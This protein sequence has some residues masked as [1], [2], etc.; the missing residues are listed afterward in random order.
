M[1]SVAA[2]SVAGA[3]A[4]T[5]TRDGAPRSAFSDLAR[6]V[7]WGLGAGVVAGL[8]TKFSPV[9]AKPLAIAGAG[10]AAALAVGGA[11]AWG[12]ARGDSMPPLP[13]NDATPENPGSITPPPWHQEPQ[14]HGRRIGETYESDY[15]CTGTG[16]D[17]KCSWET[18]YDQLRLAEP[19][20]HRGA[21][22]SVRDAIAATA[23]GHAVAILKEE[24]GRYRPYNLQGS[25]D[26]N[27]D[28]I[29][30][31]DDD[32]AAVVLENG[33]VWD[34]RRGDNLFATGSTKRTKVLGDLSGDRI[35][36]VV[37]R[38]R[39]DANVHID[40]VISDAA[41]H[42]NVQQAIGEA[43]SMDG[44]QA[45]IARGDRY[46]AVDVDMSG[47][48]PDRAQLLGVLRKASDDVVA[49][50]YRNELLVPNGDYWVYP[51]D[52]RA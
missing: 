40:K 19:I 7:G 12:H 36:E 39:S 29:Q 27:P 45:V 2:V 3:P 23:S 34:K 18:D 8:L 15:V 1:S 35:A 31:V 10:I 25:I 24:G 4:R 49:M 42:Q 37:L 48:D 44:D 21:Y 13:D 22:S 26:R 17:Q 41:G 47:N 32:V 5:P 43:I 30:D 11:V 38:G 16:D 14:K 50:E 9:G 28:R 51:R 46:Y 52:P 20:G 33:E 6:P